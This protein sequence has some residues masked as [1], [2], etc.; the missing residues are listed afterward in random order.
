MAVNKEAG[1]HVYKM[2]SKPRGIA[3]IINNEKFR[4]MRSRPG[5]NED[6]EN[7]QGLFSWLNFDT[8]RPYKDLTGN[9]MRQTLEEV[10]DMDHSN[11]DCLMVAILSHGVKGD[12]VSGRVGNIS[13]KQIIEVFSDQKCPTLAGKPK[14]FII[15]ACRGRKVNIGVLQENANSKDDTDASDDGDVTDEDDEDD[16]IDEG[17]DMTDVGPAVHPN[18]SDYIV[19]YSTIPDHVAFRG[20]TGSIFIT[21]LTEKFRRH[22]HKEDMITILERVIHD[23][24]QYQ[25]KSDNLE[26]KNSR[27]SPEVRFSLKGKIY[28]NPSADYS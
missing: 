7:L 9:E 13:I 11:Y 14:I 20:S 16:D 12:V 17:D 22:A 25:P 1:L 3:V 28:F 10:A 24:T 18:I 19:A 4:R 5:T 26:Y 15:Q 8:K 21:K 2:E 27:Q 23:V 6:A